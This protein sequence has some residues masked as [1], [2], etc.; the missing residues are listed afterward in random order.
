Y[1]SVLMQNWIELN[2]Y[3]SPEG[4]AVYF[5]T[6][7]EQKVMAARIA[8]SERRLNFVTLATLD[9]AWDWNLETD[10]IW[11]SG[12]LERLFGYESAPGAPE[13]ETK[14]QFWVDQI[15]NDDR[16]RVLGNLTRVI[17]GDARTWEE[18]YRF[19]HRDSQFV[20]V[21]HRGFVIRDDK[22]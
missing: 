18:R 4:L 17:D 7:T 14:R 11:W 21:E 3:P 20:H 16:S 9:A 6:V 5:R 12:A 1:Y 10:R 22:G 8:A 13:L 15:H 2:A 19:K